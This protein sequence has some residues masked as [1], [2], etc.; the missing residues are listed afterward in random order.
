[1]KFSILTFLLSLSLI[2]RVAIAG[3]PPAKLHS[4]GFLTERSSATEEIATLKKELAEIGYVD[5]ETMKV[6]S[7]SSGGHIER[8]DEAAATLM[9]QKPDLIVADGV[10]SGQAARRQTRSVPIVVASRLETIRAG[11]NITGATNISG[12]LGIQRLRLLKEIS[13]SLSRIAILWHEV[14]PIPSNYIKQV[15][16]AANSLG[17]EIDPHK[18]RSSSQFQAT[19]DAMAA[20]KD[21]GAI[22]ESQLLFTSRMGEIVG[23][24]SKARLASIS[25]VEE[26]AAAGGLVSYGLSAE[27]MWHHTAVLIDRIFKLRKPKSGQPLELPAAQPEKFQLVVNL[28][29]AA[30]LRLSVSP[31]VLKRADKVIK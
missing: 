25:G 1:M 21:D 10:S 31:D 24:L 23:L 19:F 20:S 29:T 9:Q 3:E 2:A 30:Q 6:F 12:D 26:F 17:V 7:S 13:P 28:K 27:Q 16:K 4:I 11:G 5:G 22:I 8:I 18:L 14:N 15:R